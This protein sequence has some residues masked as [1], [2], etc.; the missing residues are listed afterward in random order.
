M[1]TVTKF[2]HLFNDCRRLSRSEEIETWRQAK[3]GDD[4]ARTALIESVLPW[5][6]EL[7]R[8]IA[9]R[10]RLDVDEC[11][12][13]AA[14]ELVEACDSYDA[15]RGRLTTWAT[16]PITWALLNYSKV[17]TVPVTRPRSIPK[18]DDG[19]AAWKAVRRGS[20]LGVKTHMKTMEPRRHDKP[21]TDD[22]TTPVD[23]EHAI[24]SLPQRHRLAI[25]GYLAGRFD[26]EIAVDLGCSG[27]W[28]AQLRNKAIEM[29]KEKLNPEGAT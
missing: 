27:A 29:L 21:W 1:S 16:A 8:R 14:V 13:I 7:A 12:A 15:E 5:A 9:R 24:A 23:L 4:E 17:A 22:G 19:A 20:S 3:A 25:A 6:Y 10:Y 11:R 28:V 26:R 18:H 2:A